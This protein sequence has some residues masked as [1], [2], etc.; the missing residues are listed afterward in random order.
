[1]I[2]FKA[3]ATPMYQF[4]K[5]F[6]NHQDIVRIARN[7]SDDDQKHSRSKKGN[8]LSE[9][10]DLR[11]HEELQTL[12]R[13]FEMCI[14][15]AAKAA[16]QHCW[17]EEETKAKAEITSIWSWSSNDYHNPYHG[18]PN[19]SWSGIYYL[20]VED[21]VNQGHT[22][23]H[24]VLPHTGYT[25]EGLLFMNSEQSI[26]IIPRPGLLHVFPGYVK[27]EGMPYKGPERRTIIAFNTQVKLRDNI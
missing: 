2:E 6:T 24:S 11:Q 1:M 3:W 18:H 14:N 22:K 16:N 25:D 4:D 17:T 8:V 5:I 13:W 7:W 27:H 12:C 20:E 9:Y 26:D 10:S 19:T 15:T 23:M 21:C